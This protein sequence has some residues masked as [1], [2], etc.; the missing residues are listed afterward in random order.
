[1]NGQ[2][3]KNSMRLIQLGIAPNKAHNY[4]LRKWQRALWKV[5]L[6]TWRSFLIFGIMYLIYNLFS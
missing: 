5:T 1:M 2:S 6:W 4:A 3:I